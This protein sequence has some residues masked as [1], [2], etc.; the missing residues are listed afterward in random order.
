MRA[1]MSHV[2]LAISNLTCH[3]HLIEDIER[4]I[5]SRLTDRLQE[6]ALSQVHDNVPAPAQLAQGLSA[7]K[8]NSYE[9]RSIYAATKDID[10]QYERG[11]PRRF[12]AEALLAAPLPADSQEIKAPPT[13]DFLAPPTT[14]VVSTIAV[15]ESPAVASASTLDS[16]ST[17]DRKNPADTMYEKKLLQLENIFELI[18]VDKTGAFDLFTWKRLIKGVGIKE[19]LAEGI[20][21]YCDT[22]DTGTIDHVGWLHMLESVR[23]G[24][25]PDTISNFSDALAEIYAKAPGGRIEVQAARHCLIMRP[26]SPARMAWDLTLMVLLFYIALSLPYALGFAQDSTTLRT[27]D[28]VIDVIF[29]VDIVLNFRTAYFDNDALIMDG[30]RVAHNYLR[31][32]FFLDFVTCFPFQRVTAGLLPDLRPAKLMKIGKVVKVC[33]LLRVS[34]VKA[35]VTDSDGMGDMF[36]QIEDKLN[37]SE[38]QAFSRVVRLLLQLLVACHWL[39]CFMAV[40]GDQWEQPNGEEVG[41]FGALYWAMSTLTTVGYGDIIPMSTVERCYSIASLVFGGAFYGYMIAKLSSTIATQDRNAAAYAERMDQVRAWL[42]YHTDLP[43]T[44]R[45]KIKRYFQ[46]ALTQKAAIDDTA[47][48]GDLSPAL[49]HDVSLFLVP[50]QVRDN[51]LFCS[52]PSSAMVEILP[53][54]QYR[55]SDAHDHIVSYGDPGIAMYIVTKGY[56]FLDGGEYALTD[57]AEDGQTKKVKTFLKA[58]DSFG[59]EIILG[60]EEDHFYNV[61]ARTSI[62]MY[63][64]GE[65]AF[66]KAFQNMPEIRHKIRENYMNKRKQNHTYHQFVYCPSNSANSDDKSVVV[67]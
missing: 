20:F 26:D 8:Q 32:W 22:Q 42:Y 51:A 61:V 13:L 38:Y 11:S 30:R 52:L 24:P 53:M 65:D 39:A 14:P 41:Y 47:I 6:L 16:S 34:K 66:T 2:E 45:R 1:A 57:G 49:V 63:M 60:L 21:E 27:I 29:M 25:C 64:S 3:S 23:D 36:E 43:P 58:G 54:L 9:C 19:E 4:D 15:D 31:T 10:V 35:K 5:L 18:D 40:I 56:A 59:E 17:L 67:L 33:K 37:S 12:A 55:E 50:E 46:K 44:L 62:I 28:E 7:C 48:I